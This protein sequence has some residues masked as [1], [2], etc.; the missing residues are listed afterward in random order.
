[1][2]AVDKGNNLRQRLAN[3]LIDAT[4]G[5]KNSALEEG[6]AALSMMHEATN[7]AD[8]APQDRAGLGHLSTHHP[9]LH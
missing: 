8:Q 1:M 3:R 9:L 4:L 5:S 6:A 7:S 2:I